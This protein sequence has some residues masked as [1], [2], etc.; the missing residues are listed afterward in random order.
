MNVLQK[1]KKTTVITL[2]SSGVKQREISRKIGIDRK[3]IRRIAREMAANSKSPTGEGVA[4]GSAP[5]RV[6]NPPPWPP[7]RAE[8][9]VAASLGKLPETTARSACERHRDFIELQIGLGRNAVAIYQDLVD[10]HG[11]T[12][13]Y[14]SVKRFVGKSKWREPERFDRLDFLPGEEAQVDYGQGAPTVCPR[15]GK[16]KKPRL[17][18]MTLRFSRKSFRKVVWKSSQ[19]IWSRLHEEAFR[20]F[21][22]VPQYIVLD[23]LKEGVITPDLYEPLLNP[24]YAAM[25]AHYG[26]CADPARV[27][28]PNRKGTVESAIQHTQSTALKGRTFESIEAQNEF[29][30]RWE[31]TWAS[32][33]IHG[34]TKRQVAAMYE[35]EK[36]FLKTL[37]AFGF[38]Y[39]KEESRTVHDDGLIQV[40]Q[41]Y[42]AALPAR[43]GS[44]V[45]I[46]IYEIEIE[47]FEL[48]TMKLLRRHTIHARRG[49]VVME[50]S[51]R[52]FNP[53]RETDRLLRQAHAIG[54]W[55]A[56]L[57]T[58][59]FRR[60]GRPG[61]RKIY[62]VVNLARK[63]TAAKIEAASR[64]AFERGAYSGAV[65][66]RLALV[67]TAPAPEESAPLTSVH[68][69]IR[70]LAEY[71]D[72]WD[73][74][75][76]TNAQALS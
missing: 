33:R 73:Q 2:L 74:N 58:E 40:G 27:V 52:L 64:A 24:V 57:C 37:P 47:I 28:D 61:Q 42:Y 8:S 60:Q 26:T 31:E 36:P 15:T 4:T 17:F 71:Q 44:R 54:P 5:A 72:F 75:S 39:F 56:K 50:E 11:F 16:L 63:T 68:E 51:D 25:L 53:S 19:E 46:R 62:A 12:N 67:E 69:A 76:Q 48:P 43:I 70:P 35:E 1:D 7:G 29:L 32:K 59:I 38:R 10:E 41:S 20:Y 66:R 13:A 34:R 18:V 21:G 22:G 23:N 65:V 45:I 49:S 6:Q 3:T 30:M 14:N 9:E 55:T